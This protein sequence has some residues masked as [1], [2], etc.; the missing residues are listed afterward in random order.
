[1]REHLATCTSCSDYYRRQLIL[2]RLDPAALSS[3][4]RIARGL[5]L[6]RRGAGALVPVGL[7]ALVAAAAAVLLVAR[8]HPAREA[9]AS[10]GSSVADTAPASRVFVYDVAPGA[11]PMLAGDGIR[12]GDEL[13]F[14]YENGP[15]RKWL[16]LFGV[17][18]HGH[19]YWY[20][21]AWAD[22]QDD[23]V[24]VAVET[25][26]KRHALPDAIRHALDGSHLEVRAVFLES[27]VS[28][29]RIEALVKERPV[30]AL[31]LPGAIELSTSLRVTP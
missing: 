1:M 26:R 23:P 17:D 9:F 14:A 29:R 28:V 4:E 12:R 8:A 2:A 18:E 6:R 16:A 24:A 15:G 7:A 25:D 19:V 13:A 20:Y 21:P 11:A 30:G 22:P 27:P 3:E 5:G 31:D 10:R